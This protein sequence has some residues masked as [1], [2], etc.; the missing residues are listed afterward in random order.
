MFA[1]L[2]VVVILWLLIVLIILIFVLYISFDFKL[3]ARVVVCLG[4][5]YLWY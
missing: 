2:M 5:V 3:D 1:D 4:M